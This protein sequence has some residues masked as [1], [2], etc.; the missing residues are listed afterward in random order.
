MCP[1]LWASVVFTAYSTASY[2][3]HFFILRANEA[4]VTVDY[5]F[6]VDYCGVLPIV[7]E[8]RMTRIIC[9]KFIIIIIVII[10]VVIISCL[11]VAVCG[12]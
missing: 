12:L 5:F 8:V 9:G 10:I 7:A 11:S 6:N 3:T 1:S 4:L 2:V